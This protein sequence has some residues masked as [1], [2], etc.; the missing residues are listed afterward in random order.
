MDTQIDPRTQDVMNMIETLHESVRNGA[1]FDRKLD[2]LADAMAAAGTMDRAAI[3]DAM[4]RGAT[5][6]LANELIAA[7]QSFM[8]CAML[9]EK[10]QDRQRAQDCVV[11]IDDVLGRLNQRG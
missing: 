7:R 8:A 5:E 11:Q 10:P 6:K 1:E 3:Y 4:Q 2:Q 9:A